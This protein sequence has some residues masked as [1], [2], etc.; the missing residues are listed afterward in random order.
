MPF[1]T[2]EQFNDGLLKH[3]GQK[4]ADISPN[5]GTL[6]GVQEYPRY[7][8]PKM[9]VLFFLNTI[10]SLGFG[11][12][13]SVFCDWS[14]LKD[15]DNDSMTPSPTF[16]PD[17]VMTF[18]Y[19]GTVLMGIGA[20]II[21][22]FLA[23]IS[24][25]AIAK[26]T[27]CL[28]YCGGILQMLMWLIL[29]LFFGSFLFL[30]FGGLFLFFY[31]MLLCRKDSIEFAIWVVQ[32]SCKVIKEHRG[33]IR[34]ALV[35]NLLQAVVCSAY[36]VMALGSYAMY[37][38]FA[39]IYIMFSTYWVAEVMSNIMVVTVS[40]LAT[41]WSIGLHRMN[42]AV[43]A[44]FKYSVTYALGS[45]C[46]GSLIVAALKTARLIARMLA[47]SSGNNGL[48]RVLALCCLCF[49]QMIESLVRYFNEWA[50]A[51]IGMYRKDFGTSANMVWDLLI[52]NGWEAVAN[53]IFTDMITLIPPLVTGLVVAGFS[54]LVAEYS[55]HWGSTMVIVAA[56]V[57][58]LL[59]LI[60]CSL[61]MRLIGA[62]QNVIFLSYLENRDRFY[63]KHPE[64]VGELE[65]KFRVRYPLIILQNAL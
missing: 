52:T 11:T 34:L 13:C 41:S 16:S 63:S 50:Y 8:D 33:V 47:N 26:Y 1:Q 64:I 9:M 56:V 39:F 7:R 58:G 49:L 46:L 60:L 24:L 54:A 2:G 19:E 14:T 29:F 28:L 10:A 45:I 40:M 25:Y 12:Y 3:D 38:V 62:A 18:F 5:D 15:I 57:G 44:S 37:G 48:A 36:F 51:Y 22:I 20:I 6:L 32:T 31:A 43:S 53:D 59:G 35:W 61:V 65:E 27:R 17:E 4:S 55:L 21:S 23:Y 30:I 42:A